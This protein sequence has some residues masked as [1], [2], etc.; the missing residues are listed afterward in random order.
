[1]LHQDAWN[2][3][4]KNDLIGSNQG[5]NFEKKFSSIYISIKNILLALKLIYMAPP[6][7]KNLQADPWNQKWKKIKSNHPL[8][9]CPKNIKKNI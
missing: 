8:S 4:W 2:N 5:W 7:L 3:Y 1:M 9:S 6:L